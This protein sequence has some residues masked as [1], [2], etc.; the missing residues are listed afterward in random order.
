V[1]VATGLS[2]LVSTL[3]VGVVLTAFVKEIHK[4][5]VENINEPLSERLG[6]ADDVVKS[7]TIIMNWSINVSVSGI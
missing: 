5:F 7:Y 6:L 4:T 2:F 3:F 1:F